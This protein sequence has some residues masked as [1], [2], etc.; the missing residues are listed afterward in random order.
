M[1]CRDTRASGLKR[2]IEVTMN[3]FVIKKKSAFVDGLLQ[4][5]TTHFLS[6][7]KL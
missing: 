2:I 6:T 3:T 4:L 5:M 1:D 7:M